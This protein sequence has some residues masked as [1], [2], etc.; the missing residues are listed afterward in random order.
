MFFTASS[1]TA[2]ARNGAVFTLSTISTSSIEEI[3]AETPSSLRFF[4]LYIYK[5][6]YSVITEVT[7]V[8]YV[9]TL[10]PVLCKQ[11]QSKGISKP[12]L[13]NLFWWKTLQ[14]CCV[15]HVL[16]TLIRG[17]RPGIY[18]KRKCWKHLQS[19]SFLFRHINNL[20]HITVNQYD[21][22]KWITDHTNF[23]RSVTERLVRRAEAAGFS[24]IVLTVDAPFFGIRR[25]DL[26]NRFALPPH[27]R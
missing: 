20:S 22:Q 14:I 11:P 3:A 17:Y 12:F 16:V 27:L 5:D 7:L 1:S 10:S 18:I 24:A 8:E 13:L 2:A 23:Y 21:I 4:Q 15:F 6:R 9:A 19:F 25:E 26:K